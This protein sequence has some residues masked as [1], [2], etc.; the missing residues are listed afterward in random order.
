MKIAYIITEL[1]EGGAEHALERIASELQGWGHEIR[2]FSLH[3]G[4]GAA[5]RRL[6]QRDLEIDDLGLQHVWQ[7]ARITKLHS[8]LCDF[9]PEIVHSWMFHANLAAR[10]A[11]PAK[12]PLVN[13]LR[14]VQHRR[15]MNFLE[16]HV[17]PARAQAFACVSKAVQNFAQTRLQVPQSKCRIIGNGIDLEDF[18]SARA[19]RRDYR[20]LRGLTVARQTY[21]KG[22]DIL[23]EGLSMLPPEIPWSW[24]FIGRQED[25]A[26]AEA[27]HQKARSLKIEKRLEWR[28]HLERQNL[29]REYGQANLFALP[30]RWEGQANVVLEAIAGG[31]PVITSLCSGTEDLLERSPGCL[32]IVQPN[33]AAAWAEALTKA[34]QEKA[35]LPRQ[36]ETAVKGLQNYDWQQTASR[37]LELYRSLA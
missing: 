12:T 5:G 25:L 22:L 9:Q 35:C 23:L 14:V 18:A 31:V 6:S 20:Q 3:D 21:Q 32:R 15:W 19:R 7:A 24:T 13:G 10:L 26:Y 28:G 30:S 2:I 1:N 34:W 8:L 37:F 33:Q 27:L 11:I 36:S 16:R 17:R 29:P 4:N